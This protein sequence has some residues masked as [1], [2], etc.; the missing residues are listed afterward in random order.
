MNVVGA[1][2]VS[3]KTR[4][5]VTPSGA[6][7]LALCGLRM[8]YSTESVGHWTGTPATRLGNVCHEVLAVAAKGGLGVPGAPDWRAKF[9]AA[10][11]S[12]QDAEVA[13]VEQ[14]LGQ[15]AWPPAERWFG[16]QRTRVATRRLADELS[17]LVVDG[18]N[19]RPEVSLSA[20]GNRLQGRPDLVIRE[21]VHEIRD[22]KTGQIEGEPGELK[23]TIEAQM[24][25]YAL[26]EAESA[27]SWPDEVAVVPLR[28]QR[29][30]VEVHREAAETLA[31]SLLEHLD[32]YNAAVS[33]AEVHQL[34]DPHPDACDT[35]PFATGCPAFW[36]AGSDA[37]SSEGHAVAGVL[38]EIRPAAGGRYVAELD[39]L[40]GSRSDAVAVYG[41]DPNDHA[42][43]GNLRAGDTLAL[44]ALK[45]RGEGGG[46]QVRPWSLVRK[47]AS[48]D[49]Q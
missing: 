4:D 24:N 22:Y 29:V 48:G 17:A 25:L 27:G 8:A 45:D 11:M 40:A 28:G 33:S 39:V 9:D 21:P 19:L 15:G 47:L 12:A 46:F 16:Y 42:H 32:S 44:T 13:E 37:H 31:Q 30:L 26:L 34:A 35:C 38:T 20:L 23:A 36:A 49:A 3:P 14:H 6:T 41:L 18:W 1:Y 2:P 10:W 43:V 7:A 5:Y